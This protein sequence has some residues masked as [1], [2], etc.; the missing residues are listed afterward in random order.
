MNKPIITLTSDFGVQSQG[1]GNM[2]GVIAQIAPDARIIHLMHGLP[3]FDI[4]AGARTMEVIQFMPVGFHVCVVD[5]GVGTSRK[6]IIIQVKRGDY[7]IGPD[8]G[9]FISAVNILG[10]PKKVVEITNPKFMIQ[11]VSPIFHGRHIFVPAA[12]YL[13]KGIQI[14]EFGS[15]LSFDQLAPAPYTEAVLSKGVINA[16]VININKFGSLNLNILHSVWDQLNLM[17]GQ[18]VTI[19]FNHKTMKMPFVETFG[20]VKPGEALVLKDDYGRVEVAINLGDFAKKYQ[21]KI[22]DKFKF[23]K[24]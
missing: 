8:N 9:V 18:V 7:F 12:A 24:L 16:E 1:V 17:L 3:S 22:G 13:A 23:S 15:K 10:G 5:P 11:P 2:E 19:T 4:R 6:P 14:E 21:I 20:Q